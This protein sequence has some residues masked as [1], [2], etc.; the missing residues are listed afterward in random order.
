LSDKAAA[1]RIEEQLGPAERVHRAVSP[2]GTEIAGQV[3]GKGPPLVLVHAGLGHGTL[4]WAFALPTLR[5]RFTCYC[6][7]TR[8]RGLS[9]VNADQSFQRCVEDVVAFVES[10]GDRVGLAGPSGGAMFVLGAAAR[11]RAIAAAAA[12]DPLAFEVLSEKDGVRLHD[13]VERMAG[14][15]AE[16]RLVEAGR[17]WMTEWANEQEMNALW[18]SGYLEACAQYVPVLLQALQ[19][20]EES[21]GY[22]PTDPS[23]LAK[24]KA[25]VLV[26]QG[27]QAEAVWPWFTESVR[28]V[29]EHV[30]NVSV[31]EITGA[32]HMGAWVNPERY[33]EAM[34]RFFAEVHAP[35]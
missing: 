11:S 35:V 12:C 24:I 17:D 3:Y 30:P 16:G 28:H 14:L 1:Q 32:G 8:S 34:I 5:E 7:S 23:V 2:D 13:A 31:R 6:M 25:P 27:S 33:A 9:S 19:A 21:H 22:S 29:A 26:L 4:D 18:D 20:D 15:A 10:V